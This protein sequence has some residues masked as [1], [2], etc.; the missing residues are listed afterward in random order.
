LV[1]CK[2]EGR[3]GLGKARLVA[4][5]RL[6]WDSVLSFRAALQR[7]KPFRNWPE[8]GIDAVAFLA[9]PM[10]SIPGTKF[11]AAFEAASKAGL[12]G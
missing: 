9:D 11:L 6:K 12:V 5:G 2:G 3:D 4:I 7:Q 1:V 10:A 8:S